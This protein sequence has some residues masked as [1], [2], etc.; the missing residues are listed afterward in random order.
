M[1]LSGALVLQRENILVEAP[2][3]PN[4][5][6][7]SSQSDKNRYSTPRKFRASLT[8]NGPTT[9]EKYLVNM[10]DIYMSGKLVSSADVPIG[11]S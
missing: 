7:G 1:M 3:P 2:V 5:V 10:D 8:S 9:A 6:L 11:S 4:D